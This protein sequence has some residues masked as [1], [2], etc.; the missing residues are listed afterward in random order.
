M[1]TQGR[2]GAHAT[3]GSH[4]LDQGVEQILSLLQS[5][6]VSPLE[7][8]EEVLRRLDDWEPRLNAFISVDAE[9]ALTLSSQL[10]P[11]DLTGRALWG[12]PVAIKD[13]IDVAGIKTTAGSR[14][15]HRVAATDA[16]CARRLADAGAVC[17]G[18]TNLPELAYGPTD[19]Y[20]FGATYNPWNCGHFPGGSSMGSGAAVAAGVV[21]VAL[22][23]DTTGS[24]RNP[25]S[26]SGVTG[27]KPTRGLIPT[28]GML[29]LSPNLDHVGP[30]GRSAL[31]CAHLM[32]VLS[33][34]PRL[35][36]SRQNPD[37]TDPSFVRAAKAPLEHARIGVLRDLYTHLSP[38]LLGPLDDAL[39]VL[40]THGVEVVDARTS[41]WEEAA[42]AALVVLSYEAARTHLSLLMSDADVLQPQVRERLEAGLRVSTGQYVAALRCGQRFSAELA[43][44]F[45]TVE[46]LAL[47][48]RERTAPA[49]SSG[50]H[51]PPGDL[52]FLFNAPSNLAG[53]P[54]L[55]FP[56]GFDSGGLPIGLQ[57]VG[58]TGHDSAL[59]QLGAS[60][61]SA[62]TWH[63]QLPLL[64]P[65]GDRPPRKS[66]H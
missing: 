59:L 18:K 39:A 40:A 58:P 24:V 36:G 57:L 60:Y 53:V 15:L 29:P 63:T 31:D 64:Q 45:S 3:N 20:A 27:L 43:Q 48:S 34:R 30:I 5:R 50:G 12:L 44:V 32:E 51:R 49:I 1:T 13:N 35:R 19:T 65:T 8:V 21:P 16:Q 42:E 6:D 62:T 61:Q 23:S 41:G 10:N 54:A 25:A 38:S 56:V 4:A 17:I 7:L 66:S 52:G 11:R 46:A 2:V 47:P 14:A 55:V 33:T 26:W 9:R 28:T 37:G 22:G